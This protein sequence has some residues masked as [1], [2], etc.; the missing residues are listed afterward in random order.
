M[1]MRKAYS[2]ESHRLAW[3]QEFKPNVTSPDISYT[4]GRATDKYGR[5]M[6]GS[7]RTREP[8][9]TGK[10]TLGGSSSDVECWL[11]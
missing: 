9:A 1:L 4:M 11:T 8:D 3:R 6:P 2:S 7:E 5:R 10:I